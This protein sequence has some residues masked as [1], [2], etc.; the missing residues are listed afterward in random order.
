MSIDVSHRLEPDRTT[1]P[2]ILPPDRPVPTDEVSRDR[3]REK[4]RER[5][6]RRRRNSREEDAET[7]PKSES[8]DSKGRRI[9][10]RAMGSTL[11]L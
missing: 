8:D 3:R 2:P 7:P 1:L 4:L 5:R 6:E 11:P 10:I 9:D